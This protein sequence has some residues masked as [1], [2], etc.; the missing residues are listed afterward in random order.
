[1]G[2]SY[3]LRISTMC[4][5]ASAKTSEGW[6]TIG[7]PSS[8]ANSPTAGVFGME[9][10]KGTPQTLATFSIASLGESNWCVTRP[11]EGHKYVHHSHEAHDRDFLMAEEV[12][13]AGH[14]KG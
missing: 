8:L 10:K 9:I 4:L 14:S 3:S 11:Q 2:T 13:G 1:M 5:I 12:N 7:Q 6:V